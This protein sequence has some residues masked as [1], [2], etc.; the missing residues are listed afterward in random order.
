[1]VQYHQ[2]H[3]IAYLPDGKRVVVMAEIE[4]KLLVVRVET[5]AVE[6]AIDTGSQG[7][8]MV[9]LSP[10]AKRLCRQHH[11]I[12]VDERDRPHRR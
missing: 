3:G 8:H 10:D 7:S 12:G 5:G 2:P 6:K 1:L 11:Q 4:R 9:V